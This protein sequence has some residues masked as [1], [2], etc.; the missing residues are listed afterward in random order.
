MRIICVDSKNYETHKCVVWLLE[1][2][3][4]LASYFAGIVF[5]VTNVP[6]HFPPIQYTKPRK[7]STFNWQR[8]CE[9]GCLRA[10]EK[11]PPAPSTKND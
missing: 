7:I 3:G 10:E 8:A 2:G 11:I 6:Y 1:R 5:Y 9:V 4:D